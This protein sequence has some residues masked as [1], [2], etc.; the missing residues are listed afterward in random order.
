MELIRANSLIRKYVGPNSN[1]Q[2]NI[3]LSELEIDNDYRTWCRLQHKDGP[4]ENGH[5]K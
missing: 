3:S 2:V 1:S 5:K 4:E